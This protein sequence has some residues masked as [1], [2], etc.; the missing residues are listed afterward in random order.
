[1]DDLSDVV[2]LF[3]PISPGRDVRSPFEALLN[4]FEVH[5]AKEEK[6]VEQY[7][8]FLAEL[9]DPITRFLL[10]LIIAEVTSRLMCKF[11]N[12]RLGPIVV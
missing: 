4:E 12:G 7:R 11:F 10:Q 9:P 8:N 2:A 3:G 6:S 5:E 1:M